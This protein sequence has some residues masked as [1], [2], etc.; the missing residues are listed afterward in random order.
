MKKKVILATA[1]I[2]ALGIGVATFAVSTNLNGHNAVADS[3]CKGDS[4]PMKKKDA[5]GKEA[6]SCCDN[7][8]CCKDGNCTGDSCTLKKKTEK[9]AAVGAD[10][11]NVAYVVSDE[12]CCSCC[13]KSKVQAVKFDVKGR[14]IGTDA[15]QSTSCCSCCGK[16]K[17]KAEKQ[18]A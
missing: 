3:C 5:S 2:F 13:S 4:C 6:T 14:P 7:C 1:A 15:K 10:M 9:T 16:D 11:Q 18:S 8:D 12:G 17:A